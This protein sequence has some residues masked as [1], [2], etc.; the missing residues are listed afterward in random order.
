M[1][2][3]SSVIGSLD[4]LKNFP[5]DRVSTLCDV[6]SGVGGFALPLA[7]AYPHIKITLQ[8]LP[9]TIEQATQHWMTEYPEAI[10]LGQVQF[11]PLDFFEGSPVGG[12]DIYYL[13][14]IIHNWPESSAIEILRSTRRAMEPHSR[15]LIHD[16]VLQHLSREPLTESG[17]IGMEEAPTPM[18]PNFGLGNIRTYN[19]DLTMLLI[20]NAKE[21][22]LNEM[23]DLG[24]KAGLKFE[25]VWD[26]A[27][28]SL[29]EFSPVALP[30]S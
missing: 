27:E 23:I 12:Q 26:L 16:Y 18:L 2:G 14:N 25:K 9:G 1:I 22:T 10:R 20:Y 15:L 4:I 28:M 8:D 17:V 21:R 24:G 13:R 7:K 29:M 3:M 30:S 6:G 5:F 19:Q 11:V